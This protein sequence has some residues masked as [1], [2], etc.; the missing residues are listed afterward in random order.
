M[1][2]IES[3]EV[4]VYEGKGLASLKDMFRKAEGHHQKARDLA[5]RD[6]DWYDNFNDGQWSDEEKEL[7]KSRGQPV[8]TSNRIK[9]KIGFLLG[10]EQRGRS[11]PKAY[12]RNP[13]DERAAKVATDVMDYIET[14]SRF[15]R[16]ASAAFRDMCLGGIEAAE[17]VIDP[18]G[19]DIKAS[20]ID[21]GKFFYDPRS[22]EADFSDARYM[23]YSDWHDLDEALELFPDKQQELED[24]TD[25][26]VNDEDYEDKPYGL[27]GMSDRQ[28][29]RIAVCYYKHRGQWC[30]AYYT[31]GAILD[32]GVSVYLDEK[33]KPSNPIIAQSAYVTRD[34]E[35]YGVVRDMI[36]PQMEINYRR[37]M[38]LYLLKNRRIWAREGV[39]K[40]PQ[41]AKVEAAKADGFL[42]AE[43]QFGQ[44]WGF[45]EST[46]ETAGNFELLQEA[47]AELDVQG[48]NAG[49]QG[50]GIEGQSGRAILAQ[51]NAGLTE[52]NSLFDAHNDFKLRC[53]RAMWAR[54]KQFWTEPMF[55]R[56]TAD[57]QAFRFAKVN[58]PVVDEMGFP[59]IDPMTGQPAMQD[60]LA[61]M[62][63][64]IIIEAGPD[65]ISLQHEQ[66]E[67]LSQLAQSGFP[68]PPDVLIAAS[69]L[70]D[71][72]ALLEKLQQAQA[73]PMNQAAAQL[74]MQ[75]KQADIAETQAKTEK[76][77]ADTAKTKAET[78]ETAVDAAQKTGQM[79]S[80]MPV[81]DTGGF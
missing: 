22:R 9:R 58:Q 40:N 8:V 64:D 45:I 25:V 34:N 49:L 43:G 14:Q 37:S 12:P 21:A 79:A 11:D 71:K 17:V 62:D 7:L 48:P 66:F 1:A 63:V 32:E 61:E 20:R 53:Y 65:M 47:K 70:R 81:N 44:D 33:G 55:I 59:V 5:R 30:Y 69:Q 27:W 6:T 10:Y 73:N 41:G 18:E 24:S 16:E 13:D 68:I 39:F 26:G 4:E 42:S 78:I 28:R 15:D 80:V 76:Y 54:A 19:N 67:Q 52:E 36:G 31:G 72:Q 77:I 51:Q 75:T 60:A 57:E 23:G 38:A 50:R 74:E 29:V 3:I 56:V 35:R 46:S 2:M